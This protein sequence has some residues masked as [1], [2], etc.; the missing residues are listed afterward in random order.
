MMLTTDEE[1]H[2][3]NCESTTARCYTGK[4]NCKDIEAKIYAKDI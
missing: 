2:W 4:I 3:L 1:Y